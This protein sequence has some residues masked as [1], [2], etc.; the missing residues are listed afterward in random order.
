MQSEENTSEIPLSRVVT[1]Y[2]FFPY[3]PDYEDGRTN[4]GGIDLVREPRRIDEISE[5]K[6]FPGMRPIILKLNG[7]SGEFMTLGSE[8]GTHEGLFCGY[9][10]FAFRD[11]R[12]AEEKNYRNL[13]RGFSHWMLQ[14]H[15][16][17]APYL[18]SCLSTDIQGFNYWNKWHGDR[19]TMWFRAVDQNAAGD[20]LNFFA[21]CLTDEIAPQL[22]LAREAVTRSEENRGET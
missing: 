2:T 5:L 6:S 7:P 11:S 13:L 14:K 10:E 8:A 19:M 1:G 21:T 16:Q 3:P 18:P 4:N 22:R 12:L 20:L 9:L 17:L 15:P